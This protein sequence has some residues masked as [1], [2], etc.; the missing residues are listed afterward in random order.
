MQKK[1]KF[2]PKITRV[3][4]NPEQAVLACACYSTQKGYDV[5]SGV[6]AADVCLSTTTPKVIGNYA[7][8]TGTTV[9]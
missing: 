3:E 6:S 5:M 1:P 4:L 9:S 2:N 7:Y 8:V